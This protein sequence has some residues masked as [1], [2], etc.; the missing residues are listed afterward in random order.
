MIV[1]RRASFF[2][3]V[4]IVLSIV[5]ESEA[6][7]A[8]TWYY[9]GVEAQNGTVLTLN[10]Y[11]TLVIVCKATPTLL[12][13]GNKATVFVITKSKRLEG[14]TFQIAQTAAQ[15]GGL[16]Q[17]KFTPKTSGTVVYDLV[18][19]HSVG[20]D[21]IVMNPD[22]PHSGNSNIRAGM[23]QMYIPVV[24]AGDAGSYYCNY[25]DG[26]ATTGTIPTDTMSVSGSFTFSVHTKADSKSRK[27][28]GSKGLAY[29]VAMIAAS[30][31]VF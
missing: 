29:A 17:F 4:V 11:D 12:T 8:A 22:I 25:V 10:K 16:T 13:D 28:T 6:G 27:P 3:V 1:L 26:S 15:T 18:N 9:R 2:V 31:I 5:Q 19:G 21:H 30:K 7:A 24:R 14:Y 20:Y 23:L